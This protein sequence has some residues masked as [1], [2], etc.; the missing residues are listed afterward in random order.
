MYFAG[1]SA[2]TTLENVFA[3]RACCVRKF[4]GSKKEPESPMPRS[5]LPVC[6]MS[7]GFIP[8]FCAVISWLKPVPKPPAPK[9]PRAKATSAKATSAKAAKTSSSEASPSLCGLL[10]ERRHTFVIARIPRGQAGTVARKR[11]VGVAKKS[12]AATQRDICP[13][14]GLPHKS[15]CPHRAGGISAN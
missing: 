9:P 6:W 2:Q 13:F 15:D 8:G 12:L 10:I 3:K 7:A 11:V 14:G 1:H 4:V 5:A